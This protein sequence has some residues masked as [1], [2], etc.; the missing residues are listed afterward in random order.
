MAYKDIRE[1]DRQ[2]RCFACHQISHDDEITELRNEVAR[3]SSLVSDLQS[4]KPSQE[5]H[6]SDSTSPGSYASAVTTG[7]PSNHPIKQ[8]KPF[9]DTFE[10]IRKFNI[11]IF[12]I[13]DVARVQNGLKGLRLTSRRLSLFLWT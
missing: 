11:V 8:S 9:K 4:T 7:E 12:G 2:F 10:A 5:A 1:K 6:V 3:L 13:E